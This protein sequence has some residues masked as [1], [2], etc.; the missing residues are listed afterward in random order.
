M[1]GR[2]RVGWY[3]VAAV[4]ATCSLGAR[5]ASAQTSQLAPSGF[6]S[7]R[8]AGVAG[9]FTVTARD[10]AGAVVAGYRGTVSFASD[11]PSAVLP[12]NY[13]FTAADAGSHTF[14]ATL[15]KA[16]TR[17]ITAKDSA[18]GL[19]GSQTGIAITPAAAAS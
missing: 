1:V 3:V 10:A 5:V 7:P 17:S 11:D 4:A 16:G 18:A 6:P 12:A 9:N 8:T 2:V 13:T 15:K 19:T 14:A